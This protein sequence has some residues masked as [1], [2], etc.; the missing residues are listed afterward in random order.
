MAKFTIRHL[1][2]LA[3]AK[4]YNYKGDES[5]WEAMKKCLLEF[6]DPESG[7]PEPLDAVQF[8]DEEIEIKG[9]AFGQ[10]NRTK[11]NV[12]RLIADDDIEDAE[13][14]LLALAEKVKDREAAS[15]GRR[16][17]RIT[18]TSDSVQVGT[19]KSGEER[20]YEARISTKTA[21]FKKYSTA[22]GFGTHLK[23]QA[24]ELS[25]KRREAEELFNKTANA[26]SIEVKGYTLTT[27]G[28]G[29][30]LVPEGYDADLWQLLLEYSVP[31]KVCRV[32]NMTSETIV[33][34]KATG[35]LTVYYQADG[36]AGTES[37]KTWS[38]VQMRAKKGMVIVKASRALIDDSA[39]NVAD[40]AGK[41][42]V[43]AVG[44]V[45]EKSLFLSD[46]TGV[47]GGYIPNVQGILNI[48]SE[49]STGSRV[50]KS[51]ATTPGAVTLGDVMA[52]MATPGNFVGR[53]MAWHCT[54]QIGH[55]TLHRLAASVG[56]IQPREIQGL[57]LVP[58]FLGAPIIYN[59]VMTT[60]L[61]TGANRQ[62][63]IYGDIS[64]ACDFGDRAGL[65]IEISDQR[66]WD[67]DNLGIKGTVR[68]D[69]N[70]HG[71]GAST[72]TGPL[73]VL[74]QS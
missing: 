33:R 16:N 7:Q 55:V 12:M 15:A 6:K 37:S 11:R 23:C 69:M 60:N 48:V 31:R 71:L 47:A 29:S 44:K 61:S 72:D 4:P 5:D 49:T 54:P 45:E 9:L 42:I 2:D 35:D 68:H 1:Y 50:F 46:G 56:G 22:L 43:R 21:V 8:G 3:R 63:L 65:S 24:L 14:K 39:I 40:D 25:G 67:E 58:T 30:A 18:Q 38:N 28:S 59:N 51:S 62:L 57:G 26:L 74:I 27:V 70:V 36:T 17:N 41:D 19:V 66:Y 20:M 52:L 53:M 34:P 73:A 10:Q 13:D 32:V 64:L